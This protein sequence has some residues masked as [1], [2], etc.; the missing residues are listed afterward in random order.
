MPGHIVRLQG[1]HA[2]SLRSPFAYR[3]LHRMPYVLIVLLQTA[4][5][6][7]LAQVT[8]NTTLFNDV[9]S[10]AQP[11]YRCYLTSQDAFPP[12]DMKADW[13]DHV[14]YEACRR[15]GVVDPRSLSLPHVEEA[16]LIFCRILLLFT[17]ILSSLLAASRSSQT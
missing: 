7:G 13:L 10:V 6:R 3:S 5:A 17:W 1:V 12:P 2:N 16:S 9:M 8:A 4:S 11:L 15:T 14:W